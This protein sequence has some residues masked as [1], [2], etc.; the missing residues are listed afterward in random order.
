MQVITT[1]FNADFDCLAS[2][3]AAKKLYPEARMVF[4]GSQEKNVRDFF[5]FSDISLTFDRLK[6]FPMDD[7]DLLIVVDTMRRERIG[8][9]QKVVDKPGTKVHVYDHH[10]F[11]QGNLPAEKIIVRERGATATLMVEILREKGMDIS[12]DEATVL[13]LGIYEDT[14]LL[15]TT[16][17]TCEDF[18]AMEFLL[19]RGANLSTVSDFINREL[20]SDQVW[21]L[22]ELLH[23]LETYDINGVEATLAT[24]STDIYISDLAVL[25][26]KIK[27]IKNLNLLFSLARMGDRVYV[28]ARSRIEAVDVAEVVQEFGGGGH[29]TASSASIRDM[30]LLQ[31]KEKLLEVLRQKIHTVDEVREAMSAPAKCIVYDAKIS[32][33]KRLMTLFELNTLPVVK[34]E[35]PVGLITRGIVGKAIHHKMED[36]R[37]DEFMSGEISTLYS[38]SPFQELTGILLDKKQRIVPVVQRNSG[39]ILGVATRSDLL[40]TFYG[41]SLKKP[42]ILR[43]EE[44][45]RFPYS[46]N[47]KGLFRERLPQK[48]HDIFKTAGE[49]GD[50]MGC[51]VYVV[52]G[53]LRDLF[54]RIEN[55]DV[56]LVV[57]GDGIV[58]AHSLG[59]SYGG[60]VN[61]H[62]RFATAAVVLPG[63]FKIDVASARMES[64]EHPAA[65]PV[66]EEGSIRN[67]LYRRDFT[68]NS[69]AV[70]LNGKKAFHLIDF[71][72]GQKD[73]REK[74]IRI[75]NNL[76]FVEDPTRAFRAIRFEQ[77]FNF[78]IG[79]QTLALLKSAVRK[80]LLERLSGSRVLNELILMFKEKEPQRMV[81]RMASLGLLQ[82]LHPSI[83]IHDKDIS[84]FK[85]INE[86]VVW[87]DLLYTGKPLKTW[88]VYLTGLF[89]DL[90]PEQAM[91]AC[92]KLGVSEREQETVV[93]GRERILKVG[94]L[95]EAKK[96]PSSADVYKALHPL[97]IELLLF[98]MASLQK[99]DAKKYLSN[100][101]TRLRDVKIELTGKDLI[102]L[103]FTPGPL[104]KRALDAVLYA[105]LGGS[106]KTRDDEIN[107]IKDRFLEMN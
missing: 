19:S 94:K 83:N 59:E 31:T 34:D 69:L 71:F 66:V 18:R 97:Q 103:G 107:F 49:I 100:Y 9:F 8:D 64:Y 51:N 28:V 89:K 50:K 6:N 23:S 2:M 36:E 37:V 65:L 57:E 24:A 105:K 32:E 104:F 84:F 48:I 96:S 78:E 67:D 25:T 90:T 73:L 87:Y 39:K 44:G 7:I 26:H 42:G 43:K 3:L 77:R 60:R 17:T 93:K 106:L 62:K 16:S 82:F 52:G 91:N 76:S 79:K 101:M 14:A 98:L 53:F 41:D 81:K 22:N 5:K 10:P 68:I 47:I 45:G 56:D 20:A 54:L 38:D 72:G 11:L 74:A 102:A 88:L 80:N 13:A 46:K 92:S 75:L 63:K 21:L 1:H 15:T 85:R 95:L 29:P 35:K 27:D 55:Y 58:F 30:T 40:H 12:S 33:A 99:E 70:K 4:P 86:A 61:S